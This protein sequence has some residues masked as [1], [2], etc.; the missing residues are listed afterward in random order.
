MQ[1]KRGGKNLLLQTGKF[2]FLA[3]VC[4]L[5]MHQSLW[6]IFRERRYALLG[7]HTPR[8]IWWHTELSEEQEDFPSHQ[9]GHPRQDDGRGQ[10]CLPEWGAQAHAGQQGL[11][12]TG[13]AATSSLCLGSYSN[14][15]AAAAARWMNEHIGRI[16]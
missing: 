10:G 1:Q 15:N 12:S 9:G 11:P 6:A 4:F 16:C 13:R 2:P 5:A 14:T 7:K 8:A 3:L